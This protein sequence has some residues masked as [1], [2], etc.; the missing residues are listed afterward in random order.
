MPVE[1]NAASVNV[2]SK[3]TLSKTQGKARKGLNAVLG[4]GRLPRS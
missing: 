4:R 1:L 3:Q 2:G